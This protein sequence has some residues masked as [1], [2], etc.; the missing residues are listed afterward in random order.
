[1]PSIVKELNEAQRP[2][3]DIQQL[4]C[5][6]NHLFSGDYGGKIKKWTFDLEPVTEW[7]AH[8]YQI[9]AMVAD[10]QNQRLFSSSSDGE[11]KEWN[12][13]S[14][15]M[16]NMTIMKNRYDE[17]H[18]TE[19]KSLHFRGGALYAGDDK[20]TINRY[21]DGFKMDRQKSS[22]AEIWSLALSPDGTTLFS[23]KDNL[24]V[25]SYVEDEPNQQ[26]QFQDTLAVK[27]TVEGRA[28]VIVNSKFIVCADRTGMKALIYDHS[29]QGYP[30]LGEL[31]G[32][33]MIINAIAFQ[34]DSK[35]ILTSGWDGRVKV[36]DPEVFQETSQI[37]LGT[38][39]NCICACSN[40]VG[41]YFIGGKD[42]RIVRL[43]L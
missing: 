14:G 33:D 13:N 5:I 43:Q 15:E 40:E 22:Y 6:G 10:E 8:E 2:K 29:R 27:A 1:M 28:P 26:A 35:V 19:I 18:P 12:P 37:E 7:R 17:D 41:T 36:W 39:V 21:Q 24:V 20:G 34:E 31:T 38:Y 4:V 11:I 32:H 9:Y 23:A 3:D 25:A 42:G 16:I 30:L